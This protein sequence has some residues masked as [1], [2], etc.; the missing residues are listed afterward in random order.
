MTL[1]ALAKK[2]AKKVGYTESVCLEIIKA[3]CD[4]E[5]EDIEKNL[6]DDSNG[7]IQAIT[8]E[9]NKRQGVK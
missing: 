5:I 2:V 8:K 6:A 9:V 7:T 3:I 1:K 4:L